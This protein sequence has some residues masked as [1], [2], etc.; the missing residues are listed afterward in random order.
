MI[1]HGLSLWLSSHLAAFKVQ[2][3]SALLRA[4]F[5]RHAIPIRLVVWPLTN[6]HPHYRSLSGW[7]NKFLANE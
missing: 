2:Y 3:V 7:G 1:G 6:G 4:F 5:L